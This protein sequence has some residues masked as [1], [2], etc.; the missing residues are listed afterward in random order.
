[1]LIGPRAFVAGAFAALGALSMGVA[2][3][4]LWMFIT[5]YLR[6]PTAWL[7]LPVG[8]LVAWLLRTG[9]YKSGFTCAGLAVLATAV[10]ALSLNALL[11]GVRI[12]GAMGL[13]MIDAMQTAGSGLLWHLARLSAAPTDLAWYACGALLAATIALVGRRG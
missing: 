8:A 11:A 10:A 12:A 1:M 2:A 9:I 6:Q 4:V 3:G 7:A 13:D 5:L